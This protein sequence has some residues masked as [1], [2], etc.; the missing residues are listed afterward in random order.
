MVRI[1]LPCGS[2]LPHC[3]PDEPTCTLAIA[4]VAASAVA[5]SVTA[6]RRRAMEVLRGRCICALRT[7]G[8]ARS[9]AAVG[10][11]V[12]GPPADRSVSGPATHARTPDPHDRR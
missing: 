7:R 12:R 1:V 3:Q 9:Y 6:P 2:G 10:P 11:Q 5:A 8:G 4:G